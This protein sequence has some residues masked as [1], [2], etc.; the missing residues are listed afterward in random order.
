VLAGFAMLACST[1]ASVSDAPTQYLFRIP[2][3]ES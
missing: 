1:N 2:V 3:R